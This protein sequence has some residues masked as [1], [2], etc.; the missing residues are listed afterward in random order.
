[1][2]LRAILAF[3]VA[4]GAQAQDVR[5]SVF[6]LFKPHRL[7]VRA[8]P[9][10]V[11]RIDNRNLEGADEAAFEAVALGPK[12]VLVESSSGELILKV[13][14]RIRRQFR[15]KLELRESKGVLRALVRTDLETAVAAAVAAESAPGAPLEA[16]KA[17]A[18][19][20]RS[21]YVASPRRHSEFEYC[22]TTH[23][24][25]FRAVPGLETNFW[26]AVD[27]TKGVVL[28]YQGS[29]V[30]AFYSANCGGHTQP[31]RLS[32]YPYFT[33]DCPVGGRKM[34][35]GMGFCQ[36][37]ASELAR[38]GLGF[39]EILDHYFPATALSIRGT[40]GPVPS[41]ARLGSAVEPLP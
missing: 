4:M 27:A 11:L 14:G 23:C 16:L 22:D 29:M 30:P 40:Y 21:F 6:G 35:H 12:P 2:R 20:S 25:F 36:K 34:G 24:Q 3:L 7:V 19:V 5:I 17:Q 28:T 8:T 13:P 18:I 39:Q 37:G 33:V 32:G 10:A 9:G 31:S 41:N 15:G 26:L 38:Q 1:M